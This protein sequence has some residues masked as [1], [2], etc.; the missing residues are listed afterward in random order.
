MA[1]ALV[2]YFVLQPAT[3]FA[4]RIAIAQYL[5]SIN[6]ALLIYVLYNVLL[7][8]KPGSDKSNAIVPAGFGLLTAGQT[9]WVYWGFTDQA[10]ALLLANLFYILG[11]V[12]LFVAL[13]MIRR[14]KYAEIS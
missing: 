4:W 10:T 8:Y 1:F 13:L 11:L 9:L 2:A 6:L 14:R 5:Y 12:P 3:A 7:T